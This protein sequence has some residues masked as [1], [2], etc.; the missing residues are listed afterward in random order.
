MR[1]RH[2]TGLH[3]LLLAVGGQHVR[4]AR[5]H[6]LTLHTPRPQIFIQNSTNCHDLQALHSMLSK[7]LKATAVEGRHRQGVSHCLGH[8]ILGVHILRNHAMGTV[9]CGPRLAHRG[10]WRCRKFAHE[11]RGR[12]LQQNPLQA[13]PFQVRFWPQQRCRRC[14]VDPCSLR[15]FHVELL[16]LTMLRQDPAKIQTPF[17]LCRVFLS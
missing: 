14:Q 3:P 2:H 6:L 8:P 4:D 1:E 16:I 15:I 12:G 10:R 11:A 9:V 17:H 5:R 7:I 13:R